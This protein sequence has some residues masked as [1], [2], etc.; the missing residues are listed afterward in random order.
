MTDFR[1]ELYERYVSTFK[2][3]AA[4]SGGS[5]GGSLSAPD[6]GNY[7]TWCRYKYLPLF[8]GLPSDSR[9]LELGCGPGDMLDY[10][11]QCGF[12]A[13]EGVDLSAEHLEKGRKDQRQGSSVVV[14]DEFVWDRAKQVKSIFYPQA[15]S[16]RQEFVLVVRV[17]RRRARDANFERRIREMRNRIHQ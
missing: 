17:G 12:T 5:T 7:F 8:E 1:T 3:G 9:I 2:A 16:A 4:E 15:P 6:L 11:Q 13:V 14:D 10:L